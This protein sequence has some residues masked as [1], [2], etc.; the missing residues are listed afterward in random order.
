MKS[1]EERTDQLEDVYQVS[2]QNYK[3]NGDRQTNSQSEAIETI[4]DTFS[5]KNIW[6]RS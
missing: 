5:F 2:D 6:T 1:G 4:C 3:Q